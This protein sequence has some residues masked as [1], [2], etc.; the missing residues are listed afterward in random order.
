MIKMCVP[1]CDYQNSFEP[2]SGPWK[3]YKFSSQGSR[4]I[5][6]RSQE[7]PDHI[8]INATTNPALNFEEAWEDINVSPMYIPER[9]SNN[10]KNIDILIDDAHYGAYYFKWNDNKILLTT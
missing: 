5:C 9:A 3:G 10:L 7:I 6:A 2:D 1:F 4:S 8:N